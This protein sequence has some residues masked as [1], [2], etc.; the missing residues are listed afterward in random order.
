MHASTNHITKENTI[1]MPLLDIIHYLE[2]IAVKVS[3]LLQVTKEGLHF[4]L[5]RHSH[6]MLKAEGKKQNSFS[7]ADLN[8]QQLGIKISSSAVC[9][10]VSGKRWTHVY[11]SRI[12]SVGLRPRNLA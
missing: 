2:H 10:I 9:V 7:T 5:T 6:G 1:S 11:S 12:K 8:F 3:G 4:F